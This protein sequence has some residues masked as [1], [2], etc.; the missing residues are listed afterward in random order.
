MI[1]GI[2]LLN[3][4]RSIIHT[5]ML[6]STYVG[7][8]VVTGSSEHEVSKMYLYSTFHRQGVTKCFTNK[9][10]NQKKLKYQLYK[11][12]Q[13]SQKFASRPYY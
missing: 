7:S 12:H 13:I 1:C 11:Y 10:I 5:N 4:E 8:S 6:L 2:K 3:I 9:K